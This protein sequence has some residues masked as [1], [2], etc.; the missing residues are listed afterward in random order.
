MPRR[1]LLTMVFAAVAALALLGPARANAATLDMEQGLPLSYPGQFLPVY[2]LYWD[3]HWDT[4]QPLKRAPIE[5][6]VMALF[7]LGSHYGDKLAQYGVKPLFYSGYAQAVDACAPPSTPTTVTTKQIVDDFLRC[8]FRKDPNVPRPGTTPPSD[9]I[10]N[11]FLPRGMKVSDFLLGESCVNYFAYHFNA[12]P[13][14]A[15]RFNPFPVFDPTPIIF[16]VIPLDCVLGADEPLKEIWHHVTHEVTEAA[17]D[18][19]PPFYW[20]NRDAGPDALK[21]G[22]AADIC[23]DD[24]P[25]PAQTAF[26]RFPYSENG[27]DGV[28]AA[29]WSNADHAC[30]VDSSRVVY[31]IFKAR[32]LRPAGGAVYVDGVRYPLAQDASG[33]WTYARAVKENT[34]YSIVA[35]D[36]G[37]GRSYS[38]SGQCGGTV[39]FPAGNETADATTTETCTYSVYDDVTFGQTGLAAGTPW[40]VTVDGILYVGPPA[41]VVRILEGD[42]VFFTYGAVDG[43]TL[44]SPASPL[45]VTAPMTVTAVYVP[46]APP[47]PAATYRGVVLG[48]GPIG[49]WRLEETTGPTAADFSGYGDDGTYSGGVTLGIPGVLRFEPDN[50][51]TLD[52][53]GSVD[54]AD[55]GNLNVTGT[56]VSVEVWARGGPQSAYA[57]LVSKSDWN[58]TEGYSLYTGP[59]GTLR[60]FVGTDVGHSFVEIP[61]DFPLWDWQ[62][63]HIVGVYDGGSLYLYV[64]KQVVATSPASGA[65]RSSIGEM[66]DLGRFNGGGFQF[67]GDLDEVAIYGTALTNDQVHHHYNQAIFGSIF[68]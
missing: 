44:N 42:Q 59:N 23:E 37:P 50:A 41:P 14:F 61:A 48:D 24:H 62:W 27:F 68:G 45:T 40:Q 63:H 35:N 29:Y 16:T 55:L 31:A 47:P 3:N 21:K 26:G 19:S 22:E 65:I 57:Y 46:I 17:T 10:Y 36:P 66:L 28:V 1:R 58:G 43:Y 67:N 56:T 12:W 51:V 53:T 33:D 4:N 38:T 52:G 20:I 39:E 2:D 18:P 7:G 5:D 9:R 25:S 32:G 60:F 6:G 13:L 34:I 54:I 49:Y 15:V 30:V 11:V 8:E 64:D